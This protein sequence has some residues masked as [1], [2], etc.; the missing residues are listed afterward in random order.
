MTITPGKKIY[1]ITDFH[2]GAPNHEKSLVREKK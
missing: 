2:L 1:F